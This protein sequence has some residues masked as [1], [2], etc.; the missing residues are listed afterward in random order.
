MH[1]LLRDVHTHLIPN[2]DEGSRSLSE[3][4]WMAR[5]LSDLGVRTVHLTP[6]QFRMGNDYP[7]DL[8][9]EHTRHLSDHFRREG[10]DLELHPGAEYLLGERLLHALKRAEP[11]LTFAHGSPDHADPCVLVE[12]PLREPIVAVDRTA[13][14]FRQRGL[15]P[16][17]AHPERVVALAS[18]PARVLGWVEHGWRLQLDLLALVGAYGREAERLARLYLGEGLYDFVGSDLH[19]SSQIPMVERAHQEFRRLVNT[20]REAHERL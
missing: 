16:V 17:M 11:L 8:I 7:N 4:T 6:H 20:P 10:L 15:L 13:L 9:E 12:I 1:P 5:T 19:R 2:V 18:D 3:S 14:L